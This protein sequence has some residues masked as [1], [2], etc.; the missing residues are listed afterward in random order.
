MNEQAPQ[1][2]TEQPDL[3][4]VRDQFAQGLEAVEPSLPDDLTHHDIHLVKPDAGQ[5]ADLH[6][7]LAM[8]AA[9]ARRHSGIAEN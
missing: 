7:L 9:Y 6:I 1:P 5:E 8:R 3:N 2:T 4:A